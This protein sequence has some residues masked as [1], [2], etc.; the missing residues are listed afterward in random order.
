MFETFFMK[1]SFEWSMNNKHLTRGENVWG[2]TV[3]CN[4]SEHARPGYALWNACTLTLAS[5]FFLSFPQKNL[6]L[7]HIVHVK[8]YEKHFL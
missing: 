1:I 5:D 6:D 4:D 2:R 8:F 7:Q 3:R